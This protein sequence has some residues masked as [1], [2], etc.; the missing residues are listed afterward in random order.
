M[1]FPDNI[2]Y[3]K[4]HTWAKVENDAAIIGITDFAQDELGEIL[5]VDLPDVGESIT[6]DEVFGSVESAKTASDLY[7]PVSGEIIKINEVLEDE[8]E[9][10]NEDPYDKGW[11]IKVKFDDSKELDNLMEKDDYEDSLE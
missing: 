1:R 8:P 7:A 2:K 3:H 4:E 11:M 5:F 10:V 6:Q 9:I